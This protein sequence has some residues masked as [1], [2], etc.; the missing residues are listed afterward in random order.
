[1]KFWRDK[2]TDEWCVALSGANGGFPIFGHYLPFIG[3]KWI[4]CGQNGSVDNSTWPPRFLA[5]KVGASWL[6]HGLFYTPP[7]RTYVKAVRAEQEQPH[8]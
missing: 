2:I 6:G 7:W 5:Q 3:W 8:A 4:P 1:M